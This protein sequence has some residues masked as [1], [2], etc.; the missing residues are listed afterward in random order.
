MCGRYSQSADLADLV[1]RFGLKQ[2]PFHY[3]P[4]FNIAPGAE[5][6]VITPAGLRLLKWGF[7]PAW[8]GGPFRAGPS[9]PLFPAGGPLE[10]K[11]SGEE[12]TPEA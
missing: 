1:K 9:M 2:P 11:Y 10:R 12:G 8:S 6:P 7:V 3:K 5:T 4:S